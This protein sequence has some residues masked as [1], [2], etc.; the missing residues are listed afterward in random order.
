MHVKNANAESVCIL[1]ELSCFTS[2]EYAGTAS[3]NCDVSTLVNLYSLTYLKA[4]ILVLIKNT[5]ET[6]VDTDV[7]G[8]EV[9]LSCV[10]SVCCFET[11]S[12]NDNCKIRH[13]SCDSKVSDSVVS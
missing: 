11:V 4:V 8:T 12:G 13:C 9:F 6:T 7:V 2:L 3:D 10:N 5:V 1:K